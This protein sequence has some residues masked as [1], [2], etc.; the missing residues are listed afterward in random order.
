M[1]RST[2]PPTDEPDLF[3]LL[4]EMEN[5][6]PGCPHA[7][8]VGKNGHGWTHEKDPNSP[9]YM[10]WVDSNPA[11]RRSVRPGTNKQPFPTVGWNCELQKDVPL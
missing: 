3:D 7:Y 11:C 5:G 6:P 9:Y 10:E 4:D 1:P 8:A 2:P